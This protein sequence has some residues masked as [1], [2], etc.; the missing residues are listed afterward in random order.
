MDELTRS[1]ARAPPRS[2]SRR[3]RRTAP[4]STVCRPWSRVPPRA[5]WSRVMCHQDREQLDDWLVGQGATVDTPTSSATRCCAARTVRLRAL[6]DLT[7]GGGS[8]R[9]PGRRSGRRRRHAHP[10]EPATDQD[11]SSASTAGV[12]VDADARP[13]RP[14]WRAPS[15]A[16]SPRSRRARSRP[17]CSAHRR[18]SGRAPLRRPARTSRRAARPRSAASSRTTITSKWS[19]AIAPSS[20]MSSSRRSPAVAITPI[21]DG[22]ARSLVAAPG[23]RRSC[24]R[25]R[26]ASA[27]RARCGS[28]RRRR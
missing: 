7:R 26:R 22:L 27:S 28:S 23:P 2:G 17:A 6:T 11:S 16:G 14:G 3:S 9:G 12:L 19:A 8:W 4:S 21:R 25:S 10:P 20:T 1:I 24:R 5:T 13:G 18:R 15:R